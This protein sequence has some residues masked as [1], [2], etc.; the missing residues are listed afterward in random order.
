VK[1]EFDF[2]RLPSKPQIPTSKVN[3][4]AN[5]E[6]TRVKIKGFILELPS[7]AQ[8]PSIKVE[9]HAFQVNPK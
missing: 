7:R 5:Q 4:N 2:Q 3:P 6:K 8:F 1:I 9:Q